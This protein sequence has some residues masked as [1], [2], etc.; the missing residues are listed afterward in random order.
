MYCVQSFAKSLPQ[1]HRQIARVLQANLGKLF[2]KDCIS[3]GDI[4]INRV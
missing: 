1:I 3:K 4:D 2:E